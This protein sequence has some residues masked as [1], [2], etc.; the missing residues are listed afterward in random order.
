MD[1]TKIQKVVSVEHEGSEKEF[2]INRFPLTTACNVF[3]KLC[4]IYGESLIVAIANLSQSGTGNKPAELELSKVKEVF[5][6]YSKNI[7]QNQTISF[8]NLIIQKDFVTHN[9]KKVSLNEVYNDYGLKFCFL[10]AFQ[11]VKFN[12]SDFLSFG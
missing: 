8:L 9:G 5:T 10:L 12:F 1:K 11:I 2:L 6:S 3:D 7:S 4:Q